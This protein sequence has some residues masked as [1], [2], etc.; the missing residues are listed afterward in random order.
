MVIFLISKISG[1]ILN[2]LIFKELDNN[3]QEIIKKNYQTGKIVGDPTYFLF[4]D[5]KKKEEFISEHVISR[6]FEEKDINQVFKEEKIAI[7][8]FSSYW[9]KEIC[10]KQSKKCEMLDNFLKENGRKLGIIER[11]ANLIDY[12][13]LIKN[14]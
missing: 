10:L 8:I 5:D 2:R 13:Y 3:F 6:W 1:P 11:R 4:L 9:W 7:F 12:V 14:E